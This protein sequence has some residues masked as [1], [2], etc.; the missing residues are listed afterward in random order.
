MRLI[1]LL[2]RGVAGLL[3]LMGLIYACGGGT[4]PASTTGCQAIPPYRVC[5][6][7][8]TGTFDQVVA[9]CMG[10]LPSSTGGICDGSALSFTNTQNAD[11]IMVP[12]STLLLPRGLVT[13]V[14]TAS[15]RLNTNSQIIGQGRA[16]SAIN[17]NGGGAA[18]QDAAGIHPDNTSIKDFT[19]TGNQ[20]ASS[21]GIYLAGDLDS[22]VQDVNIYQLDIGV[23]VGPNDPTG[24]ACYDEL[25]N[26]NA[27]AV[28]YGMKFVAG[29]QSDRINGGKAWATDGIGLYLN[30]DIKATFI[31]IENSPTASVE[32]AG[33]G[34]YVVSPY[35][36]FSGPVVLDTGVHDNTLLGFSAWGGFTDNSGDL[37]NYMDN[38]WNLFP[39]YARGQYGVEVGTSYVMDTEGLF[40][41]GLY[42][43]YGTYAESQGLN[44]PAPM[45]AESYTSEGLN[46]PLPS[47]VNGKEFYCAN[48]DAATNPPSACTSS[49]NRVGA[50]VHGTAG[51]WVCVP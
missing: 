9:L 26:V 31:D 36:E 1:K 17:H 39:W 11:I 10:S 32:V 13:Q 44:G 19:I 6:D 33:S 8:Y 21:I 46:W 5:L 25:R 37:T 35:V 2:G 48:C 50:W 49:S 29:A 3:I 7:N 24:C 30:N 45:N 27:Q 20:T 38:G 40:G 23:E 41:S 18:I 42:L 4:A 47:V 43:T 51:S 16:V 22:V 14:G 34:N 28:S 12:N 15:I